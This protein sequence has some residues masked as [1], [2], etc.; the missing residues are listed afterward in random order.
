MSGGARMVS[1]KMIAEVARSPCSFTRHA[2]TTPAKA[3]ATAAMVLTDGGSE[4]LDAPM[5][6]CHSRG[7]GMRRILPNTHLLRQPVHASTRW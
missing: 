1:D 3:E 5:A 4:R 6:A 7:Y 2:S